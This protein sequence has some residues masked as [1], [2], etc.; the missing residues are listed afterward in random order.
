MNSPQLTEYVRQ[1]LAAGEASDTIREELKR[2]GWS[3][4]DIHAAM[5]APAAPAAPSA[6]ATPAVTSAAPKRWGLLI[7]IVAGI[8]V[9]A[10][11]ASATYFFF[12]KEDP[13]KVLA[14]AL[15]GTMDI[16]AFEFESSLR[17]EATTSATGAGAEALLPVLSDDAASVK[18]LLTVNGAIDHADRTKP[19]SRFDMKL[20]STSLAN[21]SPILGLST[22][23]LEDATYL[24]LTEVPS[25]M[26]I[27]LSPI[28]GVWVKIDPKGLAKQFV[29]TATTEEAPAPKETI[30]EEQKAEIRA[31]FI[32]LRPVRVKKALKDEDVDGVASRHYQLAV[33]QEALEAFV[34]RMQGIMNGEASLAYE[35]FVDDYERYSKEVTVTSSEIWIGRESGLPT[36][37]LLQMTGSATEDVPAD[38]TMTF[39]VKFK[40]INQTPVIEAPAESKTFEEIFGQ[41]MGGLAASSTEGGSGASVVSEIRQIQT[42]LE[43]AYSETNSYPT[44]ASTELIDQTN[45]V[46]CLIGNKSAWTS[47]RANCTGT[48]YGD[49]TGELSVES[50]APYAYAAAAGGQRYELR[51]MMPEDAGDLEAGPHCAHPDGISPGNEC[52]ADRDLDGLSDDDERRYGTNPSMSDTDGDGFSDGEE[53]RGGYNPNGAGKL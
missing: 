2:T 42:A 4:A 32:E 5:S 23:Q 28:A 38:G 35:K 20:A 10:G 47:T 8:L 45:A 53:V 7:G 49:F 48:V 26:F 36:R 16:K 39:D 27:D 43:L 41:L 31:A 22:R 13:E 24:S 18:L 33:D 3:E 37:V 1:R 9:L 25:N 17:V 44:P 21:G 34:F 51:F 15:S 52:I 11:G 19:K 12:L 40:N 6:P 30:T 50:E 29:G 46:L 14:A